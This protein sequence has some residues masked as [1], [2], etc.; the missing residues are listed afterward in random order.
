M[1]SRPKLPA[2]ADTNDAHA[3][4]QFAMEK[5]ST[6]ADKASDALF[7]STRLEPMWADAFY[8]RRIALL[9]S[10]PRRL[11]QYWLGDRR[12]IQSKEIQQIDSLY[13][14]SL[15]LNPFVSQ[16]LEH[17]L[18]DVVADE[19]TRNATRD[20]P[21]SSGEVRYYIDTYMQ[22]APSATHLFSDGLSRQR[23]R[24]VERGDRRSAEARQEGRHLRLP[25]QGA[26]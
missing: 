21:G 24:R 22:R 2:G 12:T 11:Q 20:A 15:T 17:Q 3:Y 1:P 5:L 16:T 6:D 4:Y 8:A 18:W 7:W 13:L 19:I 10:D 25:I 23:T 9:M 26:H 14:R